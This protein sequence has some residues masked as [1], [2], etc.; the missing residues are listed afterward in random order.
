MQD[1]GEAP[2]STPALGEGFA[3][4][5]QGGGGGSGG[6]R[7]VYVGSLPPSVTERPLRDYFSGFG[8]VSDVRVV[9]DRSTGI[10][11]GFAFVSFH[12]EESAAAAL[13]CK[14]PHMVEGRAVRV[15]EAERS[16]AG[17]GG[18]GGGG[19]GKGK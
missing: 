10:S 13:S 6:S 16:K 19:G 2:H 4:L 15:S 8:D 9:R 3:H 14:G 1:A 5:E 17:G 7:S 12:Q 11:R 18:G